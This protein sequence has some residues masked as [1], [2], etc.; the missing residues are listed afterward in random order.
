MTKANLTVEFA[1]LRFSS[2][3]PNDNAI[4]V[5]TNMEILNFKIQ[6]MKVFISILK[7]GHKNSS[8]VLH[9]T[10]KSQKRTFERFVVVADADGVKLVLNT[11][12]CKQL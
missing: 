9:F 6:I 4:L 11:L 12:E 5:G 1:K 8:A 7:H 2:L 3:M 10:S